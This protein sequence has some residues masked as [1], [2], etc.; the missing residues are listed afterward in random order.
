[1][2]IQ[3]IAFSLLPISF[4]GTICNWLTVLLCYKSTSLKNA[5]VY[6]TANQALGDA[7][8]ST[9]FLFYIAPM[10]ILNDPALSPY[11]NNLKCKIIFD[12]TTLMFRYPDTPTCNSELVFVCEILTYFAISPYVE[13]KYF[14]FF[15][16]TFSW[17][18]IHAIDGILT[19]VFNS[20]LRIF[21]EKRKELKLT[22]M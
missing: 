8:H 16:T 13:N 15:L 5:F 1:M 11:L 4:I 10:I 21:R 9:I 19:L 22:E 6:L 12:F 2:P 7:I 14:K 3:W 20:S 18:S 17:C